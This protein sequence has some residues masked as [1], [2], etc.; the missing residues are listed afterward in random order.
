MSDRYEGQ[1]RVYSDDPYLIWNAKE[2]AWFAEDGTVINQDR[3]MAICDELSQSYELSLTREAADRLTEVSDESVPVTSSFT[4]WDGFEWKSFQKRCLNCLSKR[5]RGMIQSSPGT[6]KTMMGTFLFAKRMD[7]GEI[8]RA[9]VWCPASLVTDWID[10]IRRTT[11]LTVATVDKSA[12][13]KKR[14]EFYAQSTAQVWVLNYER[15]RTSDYKAIEARLR[16]QKVMFVWD[17]IQKLGNRKS[18]LSKH[19]AMLSNHVRCEYRIG[20][21][22]TPIVTGPE[23]FYNEFRVI[24][25]DKFGLVRDFERDFTVNNGERDFW[26]NYVGYQ[27]LEYMHARVG[28][29]IFSASKSQPEIAVEFPQRNE[30]I[31]PLELSR[32]ERALYDDIMDYG[33]TLDPDTRSGTLFMLMFVRLCN[34]PE[35]LLTMPHGGEGDYGEQSQR[36]WE[37]CQEHAAAIASSKNS[38]K[39][40]LVTEKIDELVGAGE[41]VIVFAA[42]THNCLFPLA[43]HLKKYSPLLYVGGMSGGEQE[44]VKNRF[45]KDP[46]S[47]L[48]LMS[49]AGQVG[50]NFQEC[51]NVIH[52]QTPITHAAY[53][54]RSD[55]VHRIDSQSDHVDIYRMTTADTVEE[56][57]EETMQGRRRLSTMLGFA[58][59]YEE[60]G[61]ISDRD[62]DF[63]CGF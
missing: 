36:I 30:I 6:G 48:L 21:T 54:Q 25:P 9:V 5:Q 61:A 8:D 12:S 38:N 33:R 57:V 51:S 56:R 11:T 32:K 55:R 18:A 37:I 43:E 41:K 14:E 4:A 34:M 2:K 1:F 29:E 10:S 49:D 13:A 59:E 17:E 45:K 60:L 52:Y 28:A 23:N 40:E 63:M 42:H 19:M 15:V 7:D 31:L 24:D 3:A 20:M 47:N 27:N 39:L 22:A 53:E 35:V 46:K 44:S 26:G 62:A 58:G 16:K 50:L